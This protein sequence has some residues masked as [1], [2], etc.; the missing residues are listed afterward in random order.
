MEVQ[1]PVNKRKDV[2]PEEEY[3]AGGNLTGLGK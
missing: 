3:P 1:V 2:V